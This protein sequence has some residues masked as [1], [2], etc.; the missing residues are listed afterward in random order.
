[1]LAHDVNVSKRKRGKK[2]LQKPELTS[3]CRGKEVID[4][5]K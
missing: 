3:S 5:E 2:P 4:R 1:M